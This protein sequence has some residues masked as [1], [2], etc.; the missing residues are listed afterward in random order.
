[1]GWKLRR[2]LLKQQPTRACCTAAHT[3]TTGDVCIAH[4]Q[5]QHRLSSVS[6]S[7]HPPRRTQR[8]AVASFQHW[9]R[10]DALNTSLAGARVPSSSGSATKLVGKAPVAAVVRYA[11]NAT[12]SHA[13]CIVCQA[14]RLWTVA[15]V[16]STA[17]SQDV[18]S[19]PVWAQLEERE[20]TVLEPVSSSSS[21]PR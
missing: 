18:A 11:K 2:K 1:M 13:T 8:L 20:Y 7:S 3:R 16:L 17:G 6:S 14:G 12:S 5:L 10:S 9:A 4:V 19:R 15:A 21:S